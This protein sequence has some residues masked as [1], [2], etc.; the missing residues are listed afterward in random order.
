VNS[1]KRSF[2]SFYCF[3]LKKQT[4]NIEHRIKNIEKICLKYEDKSSFRTGVSGN[5]KSELETRGR[6]DEE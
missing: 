1:G 4:W 2:E 3:L 5:E 6:G